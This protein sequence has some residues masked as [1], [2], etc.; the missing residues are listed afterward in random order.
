MRLWETS[1]ELGN[2]GMAAKMSCL[3]SQPNPAGRNVR[4]QGTDSAVSEG[5]YRPAAA[6]S[7]GSGTASLPLPPPP[8]T[9]GAASARPHIC[10]EGDFS[11]F[12]GY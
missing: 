2:A 9:G 7:A 10:Q 11:C 12:Q 8:G 6:N 1:E 5:V 3:Q 4:V